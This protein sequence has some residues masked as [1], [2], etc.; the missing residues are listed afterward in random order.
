MQ[1]I[2]TKRRQ[3]MGSGGAKK[4]RMEQSSFVYIQFSIFI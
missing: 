4:T 3:A 2:G 1:W